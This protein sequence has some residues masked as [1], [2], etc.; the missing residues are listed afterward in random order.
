MHMSMVVFL[1]ETNSPWRSFSPWAWDEIQYRKKP[2]SILQVLESVH[3]AFTIV[4]GKCGRAAGGGCRPQAPWESCVSV[5]PHTAQASEGVSLVGIP[6]SPKA[7]LA[8]LPDYQN[9]NWHIERTIRKHHLCFPI[10]ADATSIS[11]SSDIVG[12]NAFFPLHSMYHFNL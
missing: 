1:I 4:S 6:A 11:L 12:S 10:S 8:L 2:T 5:S 9:C 3:N 7:Y